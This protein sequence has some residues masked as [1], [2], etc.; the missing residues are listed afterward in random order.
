MSVTSTSQDVAR[1]LADD[2]YVVVTGLMTPAGAQNA[3]AD[4]DRVLRTTHTGRN[5]FEG[6]ATQRNGCRNCSATTS[7]RRSWGT[8]TAGTRAGCCRPIP[9]RLTSTR[10]A[11]MV[12]WPYANARH[13][14]IPAHRP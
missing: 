2:G 14:P 6:F 12:R 13:L 1:R 11:D 3:R 9:S 4:L 7:T 8:S 10:R 5:S